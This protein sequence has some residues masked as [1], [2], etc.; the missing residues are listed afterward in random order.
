MDDEE[1]ES[2]SDEE[3]KDE[4]P[5][6]SAANG[7]D[8]H[9]NDVIAN[10]IKLVTDAEALASGQRAVKLKSKTAKKAEHFK[11][12]SVYAKLFPGTCNTI[13]SSI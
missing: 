8:A 9:V 4:A 10:K 3:N 7:F 1:S 2:Q 11:G 12:V 13:H 5:L 6:T